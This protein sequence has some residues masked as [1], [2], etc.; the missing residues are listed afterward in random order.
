[1]SIEKKIEAINAVGY[2][3]EGMSIGQKYPVEVY[4]SFASDS[5]TWVQLREEGGFDRPGDGP[6]LT[7]SDGIDFVP[8][9]FVLRNDESEIVAVWDEGRWWTPA[10]SE[11]FVATMT[12]PAVR[13]LAET[14]HAIETENRAQRRA[15]RKRK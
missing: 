10:E 11:A 6:T 4:G 1:M 14:T 13:L 3:A 8:R 12:N 5:V 9:F 7:D 2:G 15:R